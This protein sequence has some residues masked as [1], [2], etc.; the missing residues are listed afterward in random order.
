MTNYTTFIDDELYKWRYITDCK[1]S[2]VLDMVKYLI[3]KNLNIIDSPRVMPGWKDLL[4]DNPDGFEKV[5]NNLLDDN[6]DFDKRILT[7]EDDM[8]DLFKPYPKY[9]SFANDERTASCLLGCKFPQKYTFFKPERLYY[10]LCDELG[11]E[12]KEKRIRYK[13]YLELLKEMLPYIQSDSELQNIINE[14]T[15]DYIESD[16]LTAQNICYCV[17]QERAQKMLGEETMSTKS[18]ELIEYTELLRNKLNV[19]LQGAPGTGKTYTTASLAL[20]ICGED[21]DYNDRDAVMK[22]YKELRDE[23]RIGFCTFHQSMDY[24]DFIEGLK[25]QS[26]GSDKVIYDVEDGL[27]KR[28]CKKAHRD[29]RTQIDV[30]GRTD[31]GVWPTCFRIKR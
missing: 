3:G 22:R 19:I 5:L 10:S 13:H 31:H 30:R 6:L 27:F 16:L 23:G 4:K 1:D 29:Y 12:I 8:K 18:K 28:I 20:S 9:T 17:F 7:F 15:K 26:D 2:S 25:P 21:L 11:V 14:K 24:E